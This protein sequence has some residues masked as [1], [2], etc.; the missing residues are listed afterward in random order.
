M[1]MS[2]QAI[3]T[4]VMQTPAVRT[5]LAHMCAHVT[6]DSVEMDQLVKILMSVKVVL[7]TVVMTMQRVQIVLDLTA[8]PVNMDSVAMGLTVMVR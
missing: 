1:L 4:T 5:T 7:T 8:V 3:A 6:S 2:A